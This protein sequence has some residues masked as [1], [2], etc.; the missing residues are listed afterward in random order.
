MFRAR[1]HGN[2]DFTRAEMHPGNG[3]IACLQ[4]SIF[5][6]SCNCPSSIADFSSHRQ[7]RIGVC[8]TKILL[9]YKSNGFKTSGRYKYVLS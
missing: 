4:S 2:R 5:P 3:M 6:A 8:G 1:S 7:F 9:S